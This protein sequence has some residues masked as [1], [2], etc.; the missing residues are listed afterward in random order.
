MN[1]CKYNNIKSED[2]R[3]YTIDKEIDGQQQ[4]YGLSAEG[5]LGAIENN[6]EIRK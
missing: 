3:V 4:A 1:K 2:I 5:L 6:I